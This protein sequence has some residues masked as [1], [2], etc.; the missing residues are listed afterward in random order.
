MLP[1][2]GD[3][4]NYEARTRLR[5][6]IS[7]YID[8]AIASRRPSTIRQT[9]TLESDY[10]STTTYLSACACIRDKADGERRSPTTQVGGGVWGGGSGA[11][12]GDEPAA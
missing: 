9:P 12:E 8:P 11:T 10:R 6:R 2:Q 3:L 4:V 7:P 5:S 1:E